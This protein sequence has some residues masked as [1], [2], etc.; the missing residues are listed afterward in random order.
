MAEYLVLF[1]VYYC[2]RPPEYLQSW[3]VTRRILAR[4]NREVS[5]AGARL[6]VMSVPAINEVD[7]DVMQGIQRDAP[8]PG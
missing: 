8:Q 7:E 2:D 3:N 4:L 6:L 5:N 1:G